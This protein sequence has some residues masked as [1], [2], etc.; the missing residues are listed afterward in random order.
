MYTNYTTNVLVN[1]MIALLLCD[2]T[3]SFCTD[4]ICKQ[5]FAV[6]NQLLYIK[7]K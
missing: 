7:L 4:R 5:I 6:L 3:L 2:K 1:A